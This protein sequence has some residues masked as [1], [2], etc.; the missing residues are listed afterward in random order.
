VAQGERDATLRE[1]TERAVG[2]ARR[3]VAAACARAAA[4]YVHPVLDIPVSRS[5]RDERRG[6]LTP[7]A[8]AQRGRVVA[9]REDADRTLGLARRNA[10]AARA[11]AAAGYIHPVLDVPAS[12]SGRDE[13]RGALTPVVAAQRGRVAAPREDADRTVGLTR[14]NAAAVHAAAG[15][16]EPLDFPARR[17]G[18]DER[19]RDVPDRR[20]S[21]TVRDR[22]VGARTNPDVQNGRSAGRGG[23][24]TAEAQGGTPPRYSRDIDCRCGSC[25]LRSS[26]AD[27]I[28]WK[29]SDAKTK[30]LE[31]LSGDPAHKYWT[32]QPAQVYDDN[33][34][35]FHLYK[36]EN[37]SSNL[38]TLKKG[39]LLERESTDFDESALER[40]SIAF[41]RGPVTSRGLPYY[42]TS[43]TKK[44]LVREAMEGTLE[45]YK[46]N[47]H[48]LKSSNQI[49]K[50]FPDEV[51]A[52]HVNREKRR[53]KESVGWQHKRNVTKQKSKY[54]KM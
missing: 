4:G 34:L 1:G 14:R 8:A 53:V 52:K 37:F 48:A 12:R 26:G 32:H 40:E 21:A 2:F 5:G 18:T 13:R 15:Y 33:T 24:P 11:R 30:I 10:A 47:P 20:L 49:F 50:E 43:R 44:L 3:H 16:A 31:L 39:I 29:Q 36:F 22:T 35:L 28:K 7:V 38:R 46:H 17:N 42:D 9:P 51:F 19:R 25:V 23:D 27:I 41:Q 54:G 45:Q 6:A